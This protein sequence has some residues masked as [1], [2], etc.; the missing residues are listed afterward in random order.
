MLKSKKVKFKSWN[1]VD[2]ALTLLSE[3]Y[4]QKQELEGEQTVKIYEIK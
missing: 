4:I 2:D 3:L 1:E